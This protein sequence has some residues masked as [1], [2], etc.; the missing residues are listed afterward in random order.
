LSDGG[1]AIALAECCYGGMGAS[2]DFPTNLK[3]ELA[4]FHEG[5]SRVL[6]S[7]EV[8]Q[9]VE[10]IAARFDVPAVRIGVTMKGRLRIGNDSMTWID[11]PVDE[12]SEVW[13]SAL[14]NQLTPTHA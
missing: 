6:V 14:E 7:T 12:L 8:P 4:L 5:P 3:A 10:R 9:E 2:I 11:C 1:L 13:K